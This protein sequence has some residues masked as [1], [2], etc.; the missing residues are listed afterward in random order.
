MTG[1]KEKGTVKWF[2]AAKGYGFIQRSTGE[3]VFVHHTAIKMSGYRSL[4]NGS[5]VEFEL[6]EGPKGLH[7]EN[8]L[9]N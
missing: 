2:N 6:K 9:P 8:V 5:E 1:R 7:A 4:T 3:D